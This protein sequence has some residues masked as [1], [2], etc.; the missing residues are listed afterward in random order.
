MHG[1]KINTKVLE[2]TIFTALTEYADDTKA[3]F[4]IMGTHGIKGVQKLTGSWALKVIAGSNVP[5]IVVQDEPSSNHG[6]FESKA[7]SIAN[8]NG[9]SSF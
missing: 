2:G 1:I 4:V 5:F 9:V 8:G 3:D 7:N 6:I